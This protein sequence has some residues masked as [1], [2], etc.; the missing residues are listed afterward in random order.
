M[1][2][3]FL[4]KGATGFR[5]QSDTLCGTHL[6]TMI[7]IQGEPILRIM[8]GPCFGHKR[9]IS[10]PFLG[11]GATG[12][13]QHFEIWQGTSL[14]TLTKIQEEP[15]IRTMWGPCF[16]HIQAILWPF[17]G[18]DD[19]GIHPELWHLAWSIP[20]L[21]TLIIIQEKT[22]EGPCEDHVLAIYGPCFGH[23]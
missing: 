10:W 2:C 8:W 20:T 5:Q 21:G 1:F 23:F 13:T 14:G 15:I 11:K 7:D 4:G 22:I 18:K 12:Y 19:H 17:L 3:P 9:A 6:G 16:G